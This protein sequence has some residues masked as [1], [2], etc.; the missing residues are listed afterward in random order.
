MSCGAIVYDNTVYLGYCRYSKNCYTRLVKI[1]DGVRTNIVAYT[2]TGLDYIPRF[3]A[4]FSRQRIHIE[5]SVAYFINYTN[6]T[7]YLAK[8]DL[9]TG[10]VVNLHTL[11]YSYYAANRAYNTKCFYKHNDNLYLC[12]SYATISSSSSSSAA[13]AVQVYKYNIANNTITNLGYANYDTS[14]RGDE[15]GRLVAVLE[16]NTIYF[17]C[18]RSTIEINTTTDKFTVTKSNKLPSLSLYYP[19]MHNGIT[20]CWSTKA[21]MLLEHK[22]FTNTTLDGLVLVSSSKDTSAYALF[23]LDMDNKYDNTITPEE[24]NT[25]IDTANEILGEEV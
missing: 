18:A 15:A 9:S 21:C 4:W 22:M 5:G 20:Y 17:K 8:L 13:Y 23:N 12:I 14:C 19:Y 3:C 24:F 1:K 10:T 25:A 16:G 7:E 6:T 2:A 11:S